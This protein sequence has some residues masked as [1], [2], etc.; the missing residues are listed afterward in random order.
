MKISPRVRLLLF[1]GLLALWTVGLLVPD[2]GR[3][4]VKDVGSAK[5]AFLISK[6]AHVGVYAVIAFVG[7]FAVTTRAGAWGILLLLS[8]HAAASEALQP[9]V[10]RGGSVRDVGLDH[11]GIALGVAANW[12]RWRKLFDRSRVRENPGDLP[13]G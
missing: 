11:L 9:L 2:P 4:V 5:L 10:G 3:S 7:G 8:A 1:A 13:N 12:K 6:T